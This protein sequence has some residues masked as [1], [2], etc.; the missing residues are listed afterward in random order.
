MKGKSLAL[1]SNIRRCRMVSLFFYKKVLVLS[2]TIESDTGRRAPCMELL[3]W[4][5]YTSSKK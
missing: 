1:I 5:C 3:L 2:M 4:D